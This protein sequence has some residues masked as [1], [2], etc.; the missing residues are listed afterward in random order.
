MSEDKRLKMPI[1][2]VQ[3]TAKMTV[4]GQQVRNVFYCRHLNQPT[5]VSAPAPAAIDSGA[6]TVI[7]NRVADWYH[8]TWAAGAP[9]LATF[10][11]LDIVWNDAIDAGPLHGSTYSG[12]DAPSVGAN[13][14]AT[15]VPNNVTFALSLKT[16][17]LGRSFHGRFYYA[18]LHEDVLSSDRQH[19]TDVAA[20]GY[21]G[22]LDSLRTSM[23][24]ITGDALTFPQ[25]S[26]PLHVVS[27]FHGKDPVTGKPALRAAAVATPV[28]GVSYSDTILDSQRRRLPG[29]GK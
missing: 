20:A 27:F 29:R 1:G 21:Q 22:A 17:N 15:L 14:S 3:V 4:A 19:L 23:A 11:G 16:A 9:S 18:A 13:A 12:S 24:A 26:F 28:T 25:D 7:M 5:S 6:E 8:G 10:D 2:G